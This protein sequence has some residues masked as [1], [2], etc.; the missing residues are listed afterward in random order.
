MMR[1]SKQIG[2]IATFGLVAV[3]VYGIGTIMLAVWPMW[4][5]MSG[6]MGFGPGSILL[7]A[8]AAL[9]V[10][11]LVFVGGR[12]QKRSTID[13]AGDQCPECRAPVEPDYILCP[14]CDTT[15][16][17]SCSECRRPLKG[18]WTRC[19]RC[20]ADVAPDPATRPLGPAAAPS[21]GRLERYEKFGA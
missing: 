19:P 5:M 13:E 4:S 18:H 12:N 7:L 2:S 20:G 17:K 11:A 14:E 15:L 3:L 1:F 8:A 9:V 10:G 21:K 6:M 16:G